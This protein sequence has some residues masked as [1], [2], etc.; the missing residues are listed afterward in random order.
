MG[1]YRFYHERCGV[2]V[3]NLFSNSGDRGSIP[4]VSNNSDILNFF[5]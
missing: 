2:V 5:C 1:L 4:R 3:M